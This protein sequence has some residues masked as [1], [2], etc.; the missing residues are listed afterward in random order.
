MIGTAPAAF[1]AAGGGNLVASNTSM[2]NVGSLQNGA[3]L[4]FNYCSACHGLRFMRYS[5]IAEDLGLSEEQVTKNFIFADAKFG[6]TIHANISPKDGEHGSARRRP[7]CPWWHAPSQAVGL[8]LPEVVLR[9]SVR[10]MGWNNTLFPNASMPNPLWELQGIQTASFKTDEHGVPH[11]FDK[12]ELQQAGFVADPVRRSAR[13]ISAFL[14]YVAE[15][16]VLKH[17]VHRHLGLLYL[18][19]F[20][21]CAW[22]LKNEYWKGVH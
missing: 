2:S 1:A 5:R 12:F 8:G 14:Q 6:E 21:F 11:V 18:S 19:V 13:D 9:R 10:P 7:T 4:Y 17:Q 16:A 22:L 15:P 3:K 20:T